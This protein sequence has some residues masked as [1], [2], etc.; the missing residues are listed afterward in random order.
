MFV[1]SKNSIELL[2]LVVVT[3]STAKRDVDVGSGR[4][5]CAACEIFTKDGYI[6]S[7]IVR[8]AQ[9]TVGHALRSRNTPECLLSHK[10][11]RRIDC[12]ESRAATLRDHSHIIRAPHPFSFNTIP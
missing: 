1:L 3:D 12:N 2:K 4:L 5:F 9:G 6:P 10:Q 8:R 7:A 11:T